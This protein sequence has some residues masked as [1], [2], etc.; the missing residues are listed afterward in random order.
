MRVRVSLR[1]GVFMRLH[2]WCERVFMRMLALE[3]VILC[4]CACVYV[5]VKSRIDSIPILQQSLTLFDPFVARIKTLLCI[6]MP[7]CPENGV[8]SMTSVYT[9]RIHI[10]YRPSVGTTEQTLLFAYSPVL[11]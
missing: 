2:V 8:C 9:V 7:V 4:F 5:C 6:P 11:T 10:A 3:L 1:V